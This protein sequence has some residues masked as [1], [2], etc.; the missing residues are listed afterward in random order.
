MNLFT[1]E[2]R[3]FAHSYLWKCTRTATTISNNKQINANF[4][5]LYSLKWLYTKIVNLLR[6]GFYF[7]VD[8]SRSL[9]FIIWIYVYCF[10][11]IRSKEIVKLTMYLYHDSWNQTIYALAFVYSNQHNN[12]GQQAFNEGARYKE[13]EIRSMFDSL[14]DKSKLS[15]FSLF[16]Q[17]FSSQLFGVVVVGKDN[18]AKER[19]ERK[20]KWKE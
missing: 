9:L 17:V 12:I 10:A 19:I 4:Y 5:I 7:L 1:V 14:Y 16:G 3:H 13:N 2:A 18:E 20:K 11:G 6:I 15:F 8:V